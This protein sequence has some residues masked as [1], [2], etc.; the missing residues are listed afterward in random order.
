VRIGAARA[1]AGVISRRSELAEL[2]RR[3]AESRVR[4]DAL[5]AR[6]QEVNARRAHTDEVVKALRTAVYE[7]NTERV[8][9]ESLLER[10]N[11]Q[12]SELQREAPL[13]AEEVR[14]LA[15]EIELAARRQGEAKAKAAE[16]EELH[17]RRESQI[18]RLSESLAEG[19]ARQEAAKL[20]LTELQVRLAETRQKR[21]GVGETLQRLSDAGEAM[22][23]ELAELRGRISQ[24]RQRRAEAEAGSAEARQQI[25]ALMEEKGRLVRESEETAESRRSLA[26][27]LDEIRRQL[28]AERKNHEQLTQQVNERRVQL[29]EIEVRVESLVTRTSEELGLDLPQLYG[30]YQ[31]DESRD[32]EAVRA[33]IADLRAK[34]ERLGNVNLDAIAEQDELQQR[35]E[36][37]TG[38]I[39]DIRTSQR[40][41]AE[42]IKRLNAESRRRF[43][44][45]YQAVRGHFNELFRKLFG[46]GKADIL[47][48]DPEDVLE[49]GIDIVARPPGKELR[50]ISLLSGGEKT[51]TALAL[52]FS[53]FKARPSPF[54]L[55]D[56][57]DAALDEANTDRF[58][59]LLR[60]F[61]GT[62]QFVIISHAKRTIAMADQIYGVTMQEPG[63]S[64]KVAVRFEEAARMA[65]PRGK[66]VS[67]R[68]APEPTAAT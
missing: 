51:L 23:Q 12:V 59:K 47:L 1:S 58:V 41:L 68:A 39:E 37:L 9:H 18:S 62:S 56:E 11:E 61:L 17:R 52:M 29:G 27:R 4:I 50:S 48:T 19:A 22:G 2:C 43:E 14:Q 26:E 16:L 32:W 3:L 34:I 20:Q 33:E 5:T 49:S 57:V 55:L 6:R 13:L 60:E 45:S 28:G 65:E 15:E 63:V 10:L 42:L 38:Q 36:F 53:F 21:D 8:E 31:H 35:Q 46:G 24:A 66:Y 30:D 54:C 7:A 64:A 44:E 25:K 40:Q 67:E